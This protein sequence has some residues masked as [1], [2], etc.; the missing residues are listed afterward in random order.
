MFIIL[1]QSRQKPWNVPLISL[2]VI[3]RNKIG[4][5]SCPS[6]FE[7]NISAC[8]FPWLYIASQV[9]FSKSL[10]NKV[11]P[12]DQHLLQSGCWFLFLYRHAIWLCG[13]NL[14]AWM[15]RASCLVLSKLVGGTYYQF[16]MAHYPIITLVLRWPCLA[17][18]RF[19]SEKMFWSNEGWKRAR[20]SH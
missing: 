18:E 6:F 1:K 19:L 8:I 2:A 5:K 15:C 4:D 11:W 12:F 7:K 10:S 13:N 3:K 14:L 20:W 16:D 17:H 9:A